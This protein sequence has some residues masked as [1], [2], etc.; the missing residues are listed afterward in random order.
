MF[1]SKT[2]IRNKKKNEEKEKKLRKPP[3]AEKPP[4]PKA[5]TPEEV[6]KDKGLPPPPPPP[7]SATPPG[8]KPGKKR[9]KAAPKPPP[10]PPKS[11]E[12][13]YP[14][15]F[16]PKV[17]ADTA[18]D[19]KG[20]PPGVSVPDTDIGGGGGRLGA[21]CG[22]C[23]C[24]E[25]YDPPDTW[26][27]KGYKDANKIFYGEAAAYLTIAWKALVSVA[28]K[29]G[30]E[31]PIAPVCCKCDAAKRVACMQKCILA[32]KWSHRNTYLKSRWE[33][34]GKTACGFQCHTCNDHGVHGTIEGEEFGNCKNGEAL[35]RHMHK[36]PMDGDDTHLPAW[37]VQ[38][39]HVMTIRAAEIVQVPHRGVRGSCVF[40]GVGCAVRR[41]GCRL[42]R[43]TG[44]SRFRCWLNFC[45][46]FSVG[47][48]RFLDI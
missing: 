47:A 27:K 15:D 6:A 40:R 29:K 18:N 24:V 19:E 25:D 3:I 1:A 7:P 42:G 30:Y 28:E 48:L 46:R 14:D 12:R 38:V 20:P 5:R 22:G 4:R 45:C 9:P 32:E 35:W 36:I 10:P 21:P 8:A 33:L 37:W 2:G 23:T 13:K 17:V 11:P 43:L 44:L 31:K 34:V 41:V 26:W 16:M 39:Q